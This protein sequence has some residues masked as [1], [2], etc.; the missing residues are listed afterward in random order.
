MKREIFVYPYKM[1]SEAASLLADAL[2]VYKVY[3]DRKYKPEENHVVVNWGNGNRP[4]WYPSKVPFVFLNPP[5]KVMN[6]I[7]KVVSFRKF[8]KSKVRAPMFTADGDTALQWVRNGTWVVCRREL[9]GKDGAGLVLA[10]TEE[11]LRESKLYTQYVP[12]QSE[13]R[14][15]IFK[16]KMID[17]LDKRRSSI[18]KADPDIRTESN[19][20]VFCKNPSFI[21]KDIEAQAAMAVAAL[22]LDFGGVDVI[23]GKDDKSYVLEVNTAPGIGGDSVIKFRDAIQDYVKAL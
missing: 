15:Y 3:P 8:L 16:G 18:A 4:N 22:D 5:E 14:A 17:I 12:I 7:N 11:Q 23:F 9:E 13:Y 1:G 10:K 21:P 6:A 2:D 19:G 20:W